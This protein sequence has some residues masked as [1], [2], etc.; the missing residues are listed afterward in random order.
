MTR[1][2][3]S[4][5]RKQRNVERVG[6]GSVK[7]GRQQRG[8]V[9][10]GATFRLLQPVR[11]DLLIRRTRLE[12][13]VRLVGGLQVAPQSAK[14]GRDL[15]VPQRAGSDANVL[16][17]RKH[18]AVEMGRTIVAAQVTSIAGD[19][20]VVEAAQLRHQRRRRVRHV[21]DEVRKSKTSHRSYRLRILH[22]TL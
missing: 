14:I 9:D 16:Q 5:R 17:L 22:I 4:R 6:G 1:R 8:F 19:Q 7:R 15:E 21:L 12:E 11:D 3:T 13:Q 10:D 2:R 20:V 18:D